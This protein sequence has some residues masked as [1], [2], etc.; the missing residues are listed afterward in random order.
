MEMPVLCFSRLTQLGLS[1]LG[2]LNRLLMSH[3]QQACSWMSRPCYWNLDVHWKTDLV[4]GR[5]QPLRDGQSSIIHCQLFLSQWVSLYLKQ[6]VRMLPDHRNKP[7]AVCRCCYSQ[8]PIKLLTFPYWPWGT[9]YALDIPNLKKKKKN[10][11]SQIINTC[12]FF[13]H[14][15]NIRILKIVYSRNRGRRNK[16]LSEGSY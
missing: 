3:L 16:N 12:V 7:W 10:R 8:L 6:K 11:H 2:A 9:A 4:N 14:A 1:L 15:F 13:P 5:C